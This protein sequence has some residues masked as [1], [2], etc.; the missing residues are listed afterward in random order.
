MSVK[1]ASGQRKTI[2]D[3]LE[4]YSANSQSLTNAEEK[5]WA[6]QTGISK[7]HQ[8]SSEEVLADINT[9]AY[10]ET[11]LY[12]R[13]QEQQAALTE[14][15]EA[16]ADKKAEIA[17]LEDQIKNETDKETKKELKA[18]LKVLKAEAKQL[19]LTKGQ[20]KTLNNM[21]KEMETFNAIYSDSGYYDA[22][23]DQAAALRERQDTYET[24][25][26]EIKDTKQEIK[27]AD[28]KAEKKELQSELKELKADAKEAKLSK[29]EKK[30]LKIYERDFEAMSSVSDYGLTRGG[31]EAIA[32]RDKLVAKKNTYNELVEYIADLNQQIKE[33]TDK[34]YKK[35]L[36]QELKEAKALAKKYKLTSDEK[37]ILKA[38]ENQIET[39]N[40][41]EEQA[42]VDNAT[43]N[44]A[45]YQALVKR[46]GTLQSKSTLSA[47]QQTELAMK[48]DELNAINAGVASDKLTEYIKTYEKFWKLN[49]KSSLSTAEYKQ[50]YNLNQRKENIEKAYSDR[51]KQLQQELQD[52]LV[53]EGKAEA[54]LTANYTRRNE[55][56]T[57]SYQDQLDYIQNGY[58]QTA[59]YKEVWA[60]Q[61]KLEAKL[62]KNGKLSKDDQKAYDKRAEK[63][64]LYAAAA[65]DANINELE[66]AFKYVYEHKSKYEKGKLTSDE[67]KKYD[68]YQAQINQWTQ[69]KQDN[70]RALQNEMNDQLENM[71]MEYE[72][73]VNENEQKINENKEKLWETARAIAEFEVT[74]TQAI[75]DTLS[76]MIDRYEN[77]AQ[78]LEKTNFDAMKK[79]G[80]MDLFNLDDEKDVSELITEQL[81]NAINESKEK[82][83]TLVQQ[84]GLYEELLDAADRGSFDAIFEKYRQQA[85]EEVSDLV[86]TLVQQ[87]NDNDYTD[88]TW[89]DDWNKALSDSL[90]EILQVTEA[91]EN[92]KSELR[93]E[94]I[95]KAA[96]QAIEMVESLNGHLE[97]MAGLI[98]DEWTSDVNGLTFYG[99]AKAGVLANQYGEAQKAV[100]AYADKIKAIEQAQKD[101][102]TQY[103]TNEEYV[104]ALNEAYADYYDQLT[105]VENIASQL[106]ELSRKATQAEIDQI[107]KLVDVRNKALASKK[108][109]YDYNKS[110]QAKSRE[111]EAL[112]AEIDALNGVNTAEAKALEAQKKAALQTAQEALEDLQMQHQFE[113]STNALNKFLEDLDKTLD[114]ANDTIDKTFEKFAQDLKDILGVAENADVQTAYD[115][116]YSLLLGT[117]AKVTSAMTNTTPTVGST[118]STTSGSTGSTSQYVEIS[119][120]EFLS[121]LS[122]TMTNIIVPKFDLTNGYLDNIQTLLQSKLVPDVSNMASNNNNNVQLSFQAPKIEVNGAVDATVVRDLQALL[123]QSSDYTM[124]KMFA[125]LRKMGFSVTYGG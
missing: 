56:M 91:V 47:D 65:T 23:A 16:Y 86:D 32:K 70:I 24:L 11:D 120:N 61:Q 74:S 73:Q 30:N 28:T 118:T 18:E 17:D 63:L 88:S 59:N 35:E 121:T 5:Q 79:Y 72:T 94:V 90:S 108:A 42:V 15:K 54:D 75:I 87:L 98:K 71:E 97:S 109:Y 8:R 37:K 66:K 124:Q 76:T 38:V 50:L 45:A 82:V 9:V 99:A 103:A 101:E 83:S 46:I 92:F 102:N 85:G 21:N 12:K 68:K 116:I 13:V 3:L 69:E 7:K 96:N 40:D 55:E 26:D 95:F 1:E 81:T 106:V 36:K 125:E 110:I 107:K 60:N 29:K 53:V 6:Y 43:A 77:V 123:D 100:E 39:I 89:V 49:N 105:N 22:Y 14:Q 4:E 58:M 93:E 67:A 19:K 62:A 41:I 20:T 10:N 78:V 64:A 84:V 2:S 31:S 48:L 51:M 52:A 27:D 112:Q 114:D 57:Q 34:A 44:T 119:P 25:Q 117:D 104:K 111:I 122:S 113:L 33:E 80:I 115:N